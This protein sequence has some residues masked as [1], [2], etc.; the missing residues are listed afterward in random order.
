MP[1]AFNSI[2]VQYLNKT[3]LSAYS[4]VINNFVAG[5]VALTLR[6]RLKCVMGAKETCNE[7]PHIK[8]LENGTCKQSELNTFSVSC[9]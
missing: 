4:R 8:H 9:G 7:V 3:K 5:D 2:S 1:Y 6:S